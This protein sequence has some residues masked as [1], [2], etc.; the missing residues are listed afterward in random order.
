MGKRWTEQEEE[1]IKS[2][3]VAGASIYSIT[4]VL[5]RTFDAVLSRLKLMR[6]REREAAARRIPREKVDANG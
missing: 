1:Y 3:V 6:A 2:E 5:G 4:K